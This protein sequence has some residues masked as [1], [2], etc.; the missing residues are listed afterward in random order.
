M[1]SSACFFFI[2]LTLLSKILLRGSAVIAININHPEIT[3]SLYLQNHQ[4][5]GD[6]L[7]C[8]FNL[9]YFTGI[10]FSTVALF[11]N[12]VRWLHLS[13]F[14]QKGILVPEKYLRACQVVIVMVGVL[15]IAASIGNMVESCSIWELHR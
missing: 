7:D 4:G 14:V 2:E 8:L 13:L 11:Y 1:L 9:G 10:T 5:Q 6:S 12:A 15:A 3:L